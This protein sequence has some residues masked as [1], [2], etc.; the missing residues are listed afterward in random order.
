MKYV[1]T[2]LLTVLFA[3]NALAEGA[4]SAQM[5]GV[6]LQEEC[7]KALVV[8]NQEPK[9]DS[10]SGIDYSFAFG[11]CFAAVRSVV[12]NNTIYEKVQDGRALFCMLNTTVKFSELIGYIVVWTEANPAMLTF[13]FDQ[14][15][16]LALKERYPCSENIFDPP[17][18]SN[19]AQTYSISL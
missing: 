15:I 18:N 1:L 3:T 9:K 2:A 7:K 10:S 4:S 14:V 19:C 12:G 5:D 6:Y 8:L 13:P 17:S 16:V 11:F